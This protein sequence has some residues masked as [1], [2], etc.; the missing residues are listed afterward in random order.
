MI[1]L[2]SGCL[3]NLFLYFTLE[4][5]TMLVPAPNFEAKLQVS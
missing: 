4:L 1:G 3:V 5:K 2:T